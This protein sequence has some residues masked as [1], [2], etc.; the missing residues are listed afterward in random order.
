M[1]IKIKIFSFLFLFVISTAGLPITINLCKMTVSEREQCTMHQKPVTSSCCA[2][3]TSDSGPSISF[4]QSS[5]CQTEFVYK[6]VEDQYLVNKTNLDLSANE[7]IFQAVE[8]VPSLTKFSNN[9]SFYNGSSPPFLIDPDLYITNSIL[10][11]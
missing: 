1:F 7:N 3:E 11:I 8:I 2:E 4:D 9:E 10:L 5:C 6:K